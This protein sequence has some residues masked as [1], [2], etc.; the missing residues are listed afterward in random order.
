[1]ANSTEITLKEYIEANAEVLTTLHK[2]GINNIHT[3]LSYL[4][5]SQTDSNMKIMYPQ[6]GPRKSRIADQMVISKRTVDSALQTM[7][8]KIKIKNAP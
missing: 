5:I 4:L 6:K 2:A 1:M 7:S 3:A 8:K